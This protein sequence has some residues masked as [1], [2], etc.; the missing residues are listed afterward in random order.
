LKRVPKRDTASGR[1]ADDVVACEDCPLR[2][3]PS[4][5]A[6]TPEEL[7]FVSRFKSGEFTLQ[8]GETLLHEG[9]SSQHLFTVLEGW[10]FRHKSLPDGRRQI[11]NYALPGDFI[12]M[13]SAVFEEMQH[14]VDALTDVRLCVFPRKK[15]WSLYSN[16]PGLGFDLTW[17]V[18]TEERMLDDHLLSV[19]RRTALERMAYFLLLLYRRAR[20]LDMLTGHDIELP[21]NQQ[22][23]ADT[24]GLSIVHTNKT[25]RKLYDFKVISWRQRTLS[26]LKERELARIARHDDPPPQRRPFI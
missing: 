16:Q 15:L 21:L 10:L 1:R 11:L 6:F 8:A 26:V 20:D 17:L 23:V 4:F 9:Q 13:Q 14:S 24:L 19:G 2:C 12:G 22:H 18:S 3:L 5:R 7:R 25:L